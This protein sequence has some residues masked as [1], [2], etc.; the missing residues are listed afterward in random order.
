MDIKFS[1]HITTKGSAPVVAQRGIPSTKMLP[2]QSSTFQNYKSTST[3]DISS[4]KPFILP[5]HKAPQQRDEGQSCAQ[6][7]N[8][9]AS[10]KENRNR[11]SL[12]DKK[13]KANLLHKKIVLQQA[14]LRIGFLKGIRSKPCVPPQPKASQHRGEDQSSASEIGASTSTTENRVPKEKIKV[15]YTSTT[16][17]PQ[18]RD[19]GQ[20]STQENNAT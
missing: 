13:T 12:H 20:P 9:I 15:L 16:Q 14:P 18:Q 10:P 11:L 8:A 6:E 2:P 3:E 4:S 17:L 5:Q 7:N 1:Q 19:E